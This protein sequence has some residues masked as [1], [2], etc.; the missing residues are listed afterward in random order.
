MPRRIDELAKI[1]SEA[2]GRVKAFGTAH[3]SSDIA[4]TDGIH[5]SMWN[6][7]DID[8]DIESKTVTFGAG[9]TY[10]ELIAVLKYHNMAIQN[11]PSQ[12]DTNIV[13]SIMTGT[14]GSGIH[15]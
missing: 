2:P 15:N 13:G 14:H 9:V 11:L 3:S 8:I 10:A 12:T 1:V 5:V 7:K 4:D 6:F